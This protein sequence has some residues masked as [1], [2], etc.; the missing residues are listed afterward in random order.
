ME[1]KKMHL[2]RAKD[3]LMKA[4]YKKSHAA[5]MLAAAKRHAKDKGFKSEHDMK[6]QT[7]KDKKAEA[8]GMK[9]A[10]DKK[11]KRK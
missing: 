1:K 7:M 11:Y 8:R 6:K 9:K 5:G 10:M 4:G 3:A 2:E